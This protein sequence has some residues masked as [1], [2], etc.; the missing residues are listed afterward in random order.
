MDAGEYLEAAVRDV[1]TADESTVDDR[2]G[3]PK[4]MREYTERHK[5]SG[6]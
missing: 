6:S 2:V 3:Y 5:R 4:R 1:L